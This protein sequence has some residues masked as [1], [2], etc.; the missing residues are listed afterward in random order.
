MYAVQYSHILKLQIFVGGEAA[1]R[2]RGLLPAQVTTIRRELQTIR[3]QVNRLLDTIEPRNV[4]VSSS[5]GDLRR[6]Y[7]I[8][9]N[10]KEISKQNIYTHLFSHFIII[11]F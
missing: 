6:K 7:I 1:Q 2:S 11:L 10:V 9:L 8:F 3:D 5:T 4:E